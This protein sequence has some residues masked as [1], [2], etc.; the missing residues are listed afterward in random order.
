MGKGLLVAILLITSIS[1]KATGMFNISELL[2]DYPSEGFRKSWVKPIG[3][4]LGVVWL[5]GMKPGVVWMHG[6]HSRHG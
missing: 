5:L 3:M 1:S 6:T 2:E 4:K